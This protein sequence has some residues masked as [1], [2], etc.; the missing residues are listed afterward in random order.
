MGTRLEVDTGELVI[1]RQRK[2]GV[3]MESANDPRLSIGVG[4]VLMLKKITIRWPSGIVT[5]QEDLKVDQEYKIVEPK[6]G[7]AGPAHPAPAAPPGG[8]NKPTEK[9]RPANRNQL[10]GRAG[11]IRADDALDPLDPGVQSQ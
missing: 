10:P 7:A 5:T 9:K 6:D 3:S 8:T 1:H 4:A 11:E 2:G